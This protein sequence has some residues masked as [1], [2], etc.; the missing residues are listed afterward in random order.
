[1]TVKNKLERVEN[2]SRD[3]VRGHIPGVFWRD[4]E[5]SEKLSQ[6]IRYPGRD[7]KPTPFEHKSETLLREPFYKILFRKWISFSQQ[8]CQRVGIL[9]R[10]ASYRSTMNAK[11]QRHRFIHPERAGDRLY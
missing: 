8:A 2:S 6:D 9:I 10:E 4:S 1:M 7:S 11:A 3:L 5:N